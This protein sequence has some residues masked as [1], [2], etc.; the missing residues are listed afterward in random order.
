MVM[1][2][3][4]QGVGNAHHRHSVHTHCSVHRGDEH[5]QT[6]GISPD[7]NFAGTHNAISPNEHPCP[8]GR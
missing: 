6:E 1:R 2:H 3:E 7:C 5:T 4:E 8:I